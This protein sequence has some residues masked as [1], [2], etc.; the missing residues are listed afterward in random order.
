MYFL[1]TLGKL[2]F[3]LAETTEVTESL[4][5]VQDETDIHNGFLTQCFSKCNWGE[6]RAFLSEARNLN[7]E[8]QKYLCENKY[9]TST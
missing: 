5:N 2:L 3:V 1:E 4:I 6:T 7:T 9:A 8:W